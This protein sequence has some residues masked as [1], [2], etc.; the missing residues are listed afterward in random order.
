ML[1]LTVNL[2][3]TFVRKAMLIVDYPAG[4][5]RLLPTRLQKRGDQAAPDDP[6]PADL[7]DDTHGWRSARDLRNAFEA[8]DRA[9]ARY[10]AARSRLGVRRRH[11]NRPP[12]RS[13]A[14]RPA[15]A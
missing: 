7:G 8:A 5:C 12:V 6:E 14:R 3:A 4:K 15:A 10:A 1:L 9:T 13:P 2:P 11:R